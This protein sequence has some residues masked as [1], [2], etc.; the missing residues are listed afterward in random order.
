[1]TGASPDTVQEHAC[2]FV[3][4]ALGHEFTLK[5][6]A[7]RVSAEI[8]PSLWI[9]DLEIEILRTETRAHYAAPMSRFT[10]FQVAETRF[11]NAKSRKTRANLL[12][13]NGA[14]RDRNG[15]LGREDSNL[16]MAESKSRPTL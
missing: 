11:N 14:S 13:L 10:E 12:G 16:R 15:W 1:M 3:P 6:F 4:R 7:N 5:R 2:R 9:R 8:E